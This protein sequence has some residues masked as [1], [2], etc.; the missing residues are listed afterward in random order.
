MSG[1]NDEG[2]L[3]PRHTGRSINIRQAS[4]SPLNAELLSR[5]SDIKRQLSQSFHGTSGGVSKPHL[6]RNLAYPKPEDED[7]DDQKSERKR[8][9]NINDRIQELLTLLPAELFLEPLGDGSG[10]DDAATRLT[11]TK[12]GKPNKGQILTKLVDY[13][14]LMQSD[15]DKNNRRE[16]ELVLTLKKLQQSGQRQDSS[17]VNVGP[18]S[19]E[20]AL[21]EI[22]VGPYSETY[23]RSIL[24][25]ATGQTQ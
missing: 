17:S 23:Y 18:T 25:D 5:S 14:Q 1:Y 20:L 13:I 2:S 4:G 19:A 15:I 3:S 24:E 22:G 7:E 12:D 8:R 9:D 10:F 16:V 11:G 6:R 21:G